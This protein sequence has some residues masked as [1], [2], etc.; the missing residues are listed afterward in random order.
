MTGVKP[1]LTPYAAFGLMLVM[2]FA[3]LFH[4]VR[5]DYNFVPINLVPESVRH[6]HRVWTGLI[7]SLTD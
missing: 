2:M 4:I 1:K 3:A 5:G 6:V 7:P